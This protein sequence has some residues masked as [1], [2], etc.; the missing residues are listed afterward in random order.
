MN[1]M[2]MAIRVAMAGSRLPALRLM[3]NALSEQLRMDGL[4]EVPA[5]TLI[6]LHFEPAHASE[7]A[8]LADACHVPRQ[9]MTFVLDGLEQQGFVLRADH[10]TDRRRKVIRLTDAGEAMA[11]RILQRV[12]DFEKKVMSVFAAEE[13]AVF[14]GFLRRI[15]ERIG[16]LQGESDR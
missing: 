14:D 12:M 3:T 13:L 9:T 2:E 8:L 6:A 5:E 4:T 7:P 10:A 1:E 16:E 15:S 11:T